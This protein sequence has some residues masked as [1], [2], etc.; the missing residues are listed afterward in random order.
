MNLTMIINNVFRRRKELLSIISGW[1]PSVNTVK[2]ARILLVG[3]VGAGKSSFFNSINSVFKGYVSTQANTGT[4]GTS[5]TTQV[6]IYPDYYTVSQSEILCE[7][8]GLVMYH[9]ENNW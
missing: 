6:Q 8:L 1:K 5:L 3:P 9:I 7:V 2:Q 4:A